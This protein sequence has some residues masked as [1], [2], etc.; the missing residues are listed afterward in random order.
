MG[1]FRGKGPLEGAVQTASEVERV[2]PTA[3]LNPQEEMQ[4][5]GMAG[6][7]FFTQTRF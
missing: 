2:T 1:E 5:G 6:P 4:A 3:C 7:G